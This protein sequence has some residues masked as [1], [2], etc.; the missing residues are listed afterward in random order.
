[1]RSVRKST[2]WLLLLKNM[3]VKL[4]NVYYGRLFFATGRR[5]RRRG[6]YE[7][8]SLSLLSV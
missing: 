6:V 3:A 2:R 5:M 4:L 7:R 8:E 1:M